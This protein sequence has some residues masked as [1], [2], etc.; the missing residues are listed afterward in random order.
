MGTISS[1]VGARAALA[2]DGLNG[3]EIPVRNDARR[4]R[5]SPRSGSGSLH[6][7]AIPTQ[8]GAPRPIFVAVSF[9]CRPLGVDS[10]TAGDPHVVEAPRRPLAPRPPGARSFVS[11]QKARRH[12]CVNLGMRKRLL[13]RLLQCTSF[14]YS[15]LVMYTRTSSTPRNSSTM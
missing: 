15:R 11:M 13:R 14:Q 10:R 9:E 12:V 4:G 8:L 3:D 5:K 1:R 6:L 7:P 2:A